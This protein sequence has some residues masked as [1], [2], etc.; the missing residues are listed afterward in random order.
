MSCKSE[1][2]YGHDKVLEKLLRDA[3]AGKIIGAYLLVGPSKIGKFTVARI[4]AR[5][6]Q[7]DGEECRVCTQIWKNSH[8]DTVVVDRLY[9]KGRRED[10]EKIAKRTSLDQ[11]YRQKKGIGSD[12][13]GV[14]DARQIMAAMSQKKVANYKI[15]LIRKAERLNAQANNALLKFIE[16]L[17]EKTIVIMTAT[18]EE[19]LLPTLVSRMKV[20]RMEKVG[21]DKQ[22]EALG[23]IFP[24]KTTEE[25]NQAIWLAQGRI[26]KAIDFLRSKKLL[27]K[28]IERYRQ[29]EALFEQS[30][31]QQRFEFIKEIAVDHNDIP[32]F[33]RIFTYFVRRLLQLKISGEGDNVS[34]KFSLEELNALLQKTNGARARIKANA[35]PRLQLENLVMEI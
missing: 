28:Y 7:C 34:V 29:I 4:L 11:Q 33:L 1:K 20:I 31:L 17:P 2:I 6:L 30:N 3:D 19:R 22:R 18:D 13:I 10:V 27:K 9:V 21:E 24:G 23:E 26:G 16:E 14:D 8:P 32:R 35:N 5:R 15:A 12:I 25:I